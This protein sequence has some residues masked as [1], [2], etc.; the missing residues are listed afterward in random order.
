MTWLLGSL[1]DRSWNHVFLVTPFILLG[2]AMLLFTARAVDALTLGEAQAHE[3]GRQF[4]RGCIFWRCSAR[5][6]R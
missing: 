2:C 4:A 6:W 3:L 1:A 5:P